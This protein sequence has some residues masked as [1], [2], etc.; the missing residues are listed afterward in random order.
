MSIV[1]WLDFS[2]AQQRKVLEALK[3]FEDK[4]TVDDL[5]FGSIRD[6]I[7]GT[8]FP[9]TSVLQTRARYFLF[10]PW[11]FQRAQSR[12]PTNVVGKAADMERK[13]I[14]ALLESEDHEGVIGRTRGK[15][16][17]T[18][19][20][21]IYWSGLQTFGIFRRR[22]TSINQYGRAVS[23]PT[24]HIEY[25]G[26]LGDDF[27][28]FWSEMPPAPDN[29]FDF[30]FAELALTKDEARW[31]AERILDAENISGR[32]NL[33]RDC[34]KKVRARDVDFL[35]AANVWEADIS[36]EVDEQLHEL[37]NHA[38]HFSLMAHGASLLYNV[39]LVEALEKKGK[40]VNFPQ[41]YSELLRQWS[42]DA[43]K[44]G[45]S[46]WCSEIQ[47]FWN[48][49][50]EL[51]SNIP[52]ATKDF[53]HDLAGKIGKLGLYKFAL[54]EDVRTSIRKRE[55]QHKGH[56]ARLRNENRLVAFKGDAGLRPMNFR[57]TLVCRIL[58]DISDG[59]VKDAR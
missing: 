9:G 28:S 55:I 48:C 29:F 33:F 58:R 45:L 49:L 43:E 35:N 3:G 5:G 59:F 42:M 41:N 6:A 1:T 13:L 19:P 31:L 7:S 34:L 32:P 37:I 25:E 8:F 20:S 40:E 26:E 38:K 36:E 51:G 10:I 18:L 16:L 24:K 53:V 44:E 11:I 17:K 56:Q 57:W 12:W 15:D 14:L 46:A 54:D 23:K 39:L 50:E 22:G 30:E 27:E 52:K 2:E 47:D 4:E 21:A